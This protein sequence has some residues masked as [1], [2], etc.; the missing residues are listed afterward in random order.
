MTV[1]G[2]VTIRTGSQDYID[3]QV[4]QEDGV[5]PISL[6]G[7]TSV[8]IRFQ[9]KIDDTVIEFKT[10]DVPQKLF[11]TDAPNGKIELRPTITDFTAVAMY[12]F[13]IIVIDSVGNHP[14]PEDQDYTLDVIDSYPIA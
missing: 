12:R 14:V 6:A 1:S 4:L 2:N 5:T 8:T 11:I 3:W 10:T 7:V 13:H 9:N